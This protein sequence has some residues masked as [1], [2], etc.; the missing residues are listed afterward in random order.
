MNRTQH[1][2][3]A[4]ALI[5]A[6]GGVDAC[7][8]PVTR[9]ERS[10]L[11]AYR[12]FNS[13]VYM[14][15]DVI[16]VLESRAK[17]PVYSQFLFSQMQAEPQTACVVQEAADVDEAANDVWRF[18]RHAA[19]EGREL[20]ETEKREAERLLQRVDRENAELRAVLNMAAS[21]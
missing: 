2:L 8:K 5:D 11:Y 14:P 9:V 1:V 21:T 3:L 6:N 7:C 4:R 20:T 15:A 17:N 19:A 18:I 12:D 10:Q 16:D 13:G